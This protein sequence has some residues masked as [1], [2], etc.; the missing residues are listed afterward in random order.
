MNVLFNNDIKVHNV[1]LAG[2]WLR[3]TASSPVST[4]PSATLHKTC[5]TISFDGS[6]ARGHRRRRVFPTT[7][8]RCA[9]VSGPGDVVMWDNRCVMQEADHSGVVGRRV[10]H[11][12]MVADVAWHRA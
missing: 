9:S 5:G 12:G 6:S 4:G 11:R 8:R 10:M 2:I 3:F 7:P 1:G